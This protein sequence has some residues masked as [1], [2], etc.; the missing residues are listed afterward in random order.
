MA[1][2]ASFACPA[3]A[4]QPPACPTH[5]PSCSYTSS[6]SAFRRGATPLTA[7]ASPSAQ[8]SCGRRSLVVRSDQRSEF[9]QRI[10]RED[11]ARDA[12]AQ[13]SM[14][15]QI[16]MLRAQGPP[17]GMSPEDFEKQIEAYQQAMSD[18]EVRIISNASQ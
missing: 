6:A 8:R 7:A 17:A 3:T 1:A 11:A 12:E 16:E 4:R 9:E 18:P 10:E 14:E 5:T 15:Q 2:Y 13:P